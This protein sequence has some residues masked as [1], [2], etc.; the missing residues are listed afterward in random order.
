MAQSCGRSSGPNRRGCAPSPARSPGDSTPGTPSESSSDSSTSRGCAR[1]HHK[2]GEAPCSLTRMTWS[3][4][5][6][7]AVSSIGGRGSGNDELGA[8]VRCHDVAACRGARRR[9][10]RSWRTARWRK[11]SQCR[12]RAG[13][14]PGRRQRGRPGPEAGRLPPP[15]AGA[16]AHTAGWPLL[17]RLGDELGEALFQRP[18]DWRAG[19][20][21]RAAQRPQAR[22]DAGRHRQAAPGGARGPQGAGGI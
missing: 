12:R 16:S 9:K 8:P 18:G 3:S 7:V 22:H 4:I 20:R 21:R 5:L 19:L 17:W 15:H 1:P 2:V 10:A 6:L 14:V 13:G 11:R